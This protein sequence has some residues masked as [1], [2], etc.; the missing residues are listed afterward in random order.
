MARYQ[1]LI[2]LCEQFGG[3]FTRDLEFFK[4]RY[5]DLDE[6]FNK[7]MIKGPSAIKKK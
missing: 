6:V 7:L 1:A 5:S 3:L 4:T 2:T